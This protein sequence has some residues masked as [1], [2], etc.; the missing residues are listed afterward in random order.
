MPDSAIPEPNTPTNR[1]TNS[2]RGQPGTPAPAGSP[3]HAA[4]RRRRARR[5][6]PAPAPTVEAAAPV[7][8][9]EAPVDPSATPGA[10]PI[11]DPSPE[12]PAPVED[13]APAVAVDTVPE[14]PEEEA[15]AEPPI[16]GLAL[17]IGGPEQLGRPTWLDVPPAR[18]GT[19]LTLLADEGARLL[20]MTVLPLAE[21]PDAPEAA[22]PAEV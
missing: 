3:A 16:R 10:S 19:A 7:I 9:P 17:L 22:S 11:V 1:R 6:A 18:V 14:T 2:K 20:A 8:E 21:A 13:V 5:P 15:A 4:N 12:A